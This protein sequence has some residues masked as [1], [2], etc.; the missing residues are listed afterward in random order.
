MPLLR[1]RVH[2]L[3]TREQMK[4]K[5]MKWT[6]SIQQ[7]TT[8][9]IVLAAVIGVTMLTNLVERNRF[10]SLDRSLETLY[11]DRLMAESYLFQ[12]SENLHLQEELI[13]ACVSDKG[14]AGYSP[15]TDV[16]AL[17]AEREEVMGKYHATY[18]TDEEAV[19]L[20]H[21]QRALNRLDEFEHT[22]N[23][24][25]EADEAYLAEYETITRDA[26]SALHALSDIQTKVGADVKD[27]SHRLILG[28]ISFSHLEMVILLILAIIIQ[29]LVF[30][31]KSLVTVAKKQ[32]PVNLN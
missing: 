22:M 5:C 11:E 31:S 4:P 19:E 2:F 8:A 20:N 12:I 6:Y 7:K 15:D 29:G 26:F 9:A 18:L 23:E 21:L 14:H 10:Q 32:H 16:A 25:S 24:S 3:I 13:W 27:K 1:K 30:S 17:R 28:S